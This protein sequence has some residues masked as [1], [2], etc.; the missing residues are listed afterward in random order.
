[1]SN[2]KF[3]LRPIGYVHVEGEDPY[4]SEYFVN[5]EQPF[6]E[7]LKELDKFSHVIVIWWAHKN[8]TKEMRNLESWS[9]VP[10]YGENPPETGVFAT[11]AEYRPNPIGITVCKISFVDVETGVVQVA[12]LDA[13]DGTPVLDLKAYFPISDRIRDC[14]IGYWLKGWPEWQEDGATW[15][16]EQ[17]FFDD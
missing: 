4:N 6:R 17:H 12:G 9:I 10:P 8:D 13:M 11:R 5:I 14:H 7:G 16:A 1:M 2:E 15:W 3:E